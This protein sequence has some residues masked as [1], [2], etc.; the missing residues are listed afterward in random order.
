MIRIFVDW[1]EHAV[2]VATTAFIGSS[3]QRHVAIGHLEVL[4]MSMGAAD[5]RNPVSGS[6]RVSVHPWQRR[7]EDKSA[8]SKI[9]VS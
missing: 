9:I 1:L 5:C 8:V 7:V 3:E 2:I 6:Q 4:G